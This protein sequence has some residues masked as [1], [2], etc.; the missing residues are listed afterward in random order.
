MDDQV[1]IEKHRRIDDKIKHHD[2]WLGE[3]EKKLDCLEKSDATNTNEIKNL[4]QQIG[5]QSDSIKGQT[6]AIWGLVTAI[7]GAGVSFFIW[8][9]QSLGR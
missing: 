9:V 3:H 6:K 1:C 7:A 5:N 4:C 2:D 8:Y